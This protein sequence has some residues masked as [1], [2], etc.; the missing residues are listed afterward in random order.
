M[1]KI[2]TAAIAIIFLL[3]A[4]SEKG[5]EKMQHL[6]DEAKQKAADFAEQKIE[7]KMKKDYEKHKLTGKFTGT[8]MNFVMDDYLSQIVSALD[9]NNTKSIRNLIAKNVLKEHEAEIEK[10]ENDAKKIY[11]GKSDFICRTPAFSQKQ[12]EYGVQTRDFSVSALVFAGSDVYL[13][14]I[15]CRYRDDYEKDNVGLESIVLSTGIF[16]AERRI[17]KDLR[18]ESK[19][20]VLNLPDS[21]NQY[22][23]VNQ[24]FHLYTKHERELHKEDFAKLAT[25][26]DKEE[27]FLAHFG[28][29]DAQDEFHNIYYETTEKDERG[30]PKFIKIY[31][32]TSDGKILSIGYVSAYGWIETIPVL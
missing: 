10:F 27:D 32:S 5:S 9:T 31:T 22:C 21:K 4:C 16:E 7:Q 13:L 8:D 12:N 14:S 23:V 20:S 17:N 11:K 26:T 3:S 15:D 1:R 18:S 29:P 30:F 2:R 24:Y 28:E 6:I 25:E 19:F